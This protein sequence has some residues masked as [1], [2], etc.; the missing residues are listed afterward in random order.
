MTQ[1]RT[2]FES[3]SLVLSEL[4]QNS[5]THKID[6]FL[7]CSPIMFI[8]EDLLMLIFENYLQLLAGIKC[9]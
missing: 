6:D 8:F 1:S 4:I 2:Q 7:S 5:V 3:R 9:V